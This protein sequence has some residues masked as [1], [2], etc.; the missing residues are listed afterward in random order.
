MGEGSAQSRRQWEWERR[1]DP[2]TGLV[3]SD[4]RR[5]ELAFARKLPHRS[6]AK[7]L[8][9]T[10]RGPRNRGGRTRAFAVDRTNTQRLLAGG[11]TGGMWLSEDDGTT[12]SKTSAPEATSS[13]SCITQDPRAGR[14]SVWYY[15]TGENYG[16]ISGASFSALL[17]GDGIFKSV[18]AGNTW[19]QLPSTIAGDPENYTRNGSFKQVNSIVIDPT[20]NDSDVV[21]AAVF[22]GIFRSNDGGA[23]WT[24]VLGIDTTISNT[25][26]YSDLKVTSTGVYYAVLSNGSPSKGVW[27]STDGLSWTLITP[28]GWSTIA[29]RS[30]LAVD[31]SGEDTVW[32]FVNSSASAH[33]LWRY[34]YLSGDGSGTGGQWISKSANLPNGSCTGYFTFD[35]GHINTQSGYDM[36]IAVHPDSSNIVYVS[37]TSVYRSNDGWSTPG[38]YHWI[39]GY[40]CDPLDPKNYV[41]PNHH[42]DQH[43][44]VFDPLDHSVLYTVND[45]GVQR[46]NDPLADSVQWQDLNSGYITS[47]FYTIHLEDGDVS[48]DHLIGGL[49]DNGGYVSLTDD[50]G[51]DWVRVHQDDGPTRRCRT[52]NPSSC[53]AASRGG[54]TR[55]PSMRAST[56]PV[57][58]GSIPRW[59]QQL[60]L[61]QSVRA[62]SGQQQCAL[63]GERREDLAQQRPRRHPRDQQLVR[64]HRHELGGDHRRGPVG[65][66]QHQHA[67]HLAG[68]IE[69]ALLRDPQRASTVAT[70]W[71]RTP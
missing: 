71:I 29:G 60:Q 52:G 55:R 20:R 48:N 32:V 8:I 44:L 63:L 15:G 1:H 21:L 10:W 3:P 50:P 38:T 35:F 6:D 65:F 30:V 9:W 24:P 27:R 34:A 66:L 69:H 46:T 62:R 36:A 16:V 43:G 26:E 40:Q 53:T 31:P 12:W 57:S 19:T 5:K 23:S 42:P 68:A 28:G 11:V 17:A 58:S 51:D 33:Q 14:D 4:I 39:G 49:Q 64:S 13:S 54:S 2:A 37:G 7:S 18:D 45:G 70:A 41:W 47:Q 59:H 22:N 61:H 56:S 25:S 67:R